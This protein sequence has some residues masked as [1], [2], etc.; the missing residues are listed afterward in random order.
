MWGNNP[1]GKQRPPGVESGGAYG[2]H[3]W[4]GDNNRL[5]GK[6][7]I[8]GTEPAAIR[9]KRRLSGAH[10]FIARMDG[11]GKGYQR[12]YRAVAVPND[13]NRQAPGPYYQGISTVYTDP[14]W[15]F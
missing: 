3:L 13:E 15:R 11:Q 6:V 9:W 5:H 8:M 10:T 2:E 1:S 7:R 4:G 12:P 14:N